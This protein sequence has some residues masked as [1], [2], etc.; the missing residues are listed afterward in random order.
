M[1]GALRLVFGWLWTAIVAM[2]Y[3]LVFLT[4]RPIVLAWP[5]K[6][7]SNCLIWALQ[8]WWRHGGAVVV[9]PSS[10]G[11]WAHFAYRWPDGSI[12]EFVPV[13]IPRRFLK[14]I[15]WKVWRRIPPLLF[16]GYVRPWHG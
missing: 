6:A 9:V 1:A 13:E 16:F 3:L 12:E 7:P 14:D 11:W 5:D 15:G 2:G 8:Q 10:Y 4:V